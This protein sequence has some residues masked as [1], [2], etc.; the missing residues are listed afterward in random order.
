[1]KIVK[2]KFSTFVQIIIVRSDALL[3]L[4]IQNS[5]YSVHCSRRVIYDNKKDDS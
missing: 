5:T 4:N 1:M 2:K 3:T